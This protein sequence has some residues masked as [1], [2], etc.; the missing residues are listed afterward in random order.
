MANDYATVGEVK[1]EAEITD[2]DHDTIL[3]RLLDAAASTIDRFCR[4]P[5]GFVAVSTATARY[6]AGSGGPVQW[7]DECTSV[8]AVAVKD[9]AT[10]DEDDYTTWTPGTIGTTT[11]ADVF[12]ATGDPRRPDYNRTPY[13]FLIVGPNGDYSHFTKGFSTVKV[14]AKWGY[15]TTVPDD[16]K[17]ATIMQA[18]R[19][20]KR[21]QSGMSDA[22]GSP[23]LGQI[24]YRQK[25]DPDV[26]LILSAGGHRRQT[27]G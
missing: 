12:A 2:S 22:V 14:T 9:S 27:V 1:A 16:I 13:K 15:A 20:Y 3:G 8:S 5:D 26:A 17:E 10:D 6:Y 19:W 7:I 4:R 23:D 24:M 11:G 18:V 21:L 25:I